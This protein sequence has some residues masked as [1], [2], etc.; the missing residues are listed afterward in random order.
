MKCPKCGN[1]INPD[2]RFCTKCGQPTNQTNDQYTPKPLKVP[3]PQRVNNPLNDPEPMESKG[4]GARFR[5][6]RQGWSRQADKEEK[7][8]A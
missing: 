2:Q 8:H 6:A 4:L 5:A 7:V 3:T 1:E